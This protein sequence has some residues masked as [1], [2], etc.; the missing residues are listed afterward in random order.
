MKPKIRWWSD[1]L[2]YDGHVVSVCQKRWTL[3]SGY[4]DVFHGSEQLGR[5]TLTCSK[6]NI[7]LNRLGKVEDGEVT[8]I[9]SRKDERYWCETKLVMTRGEKSRVGV[10]RVMQA[11]ALFYD[12]GGHWDN[13][14][15]LE[16]TL[17]AE[18][19]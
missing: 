19:L 14:I 4:R 1:L 6:G 13:F 10:M 5:F 17:E 15:S 16:F 2:P 11:D 18:T 8:R 3:I 9:T 12:F 7:E